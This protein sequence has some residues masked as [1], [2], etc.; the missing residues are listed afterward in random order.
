TAT[1]L[2][3]C[4]TLSVPQPPDSTM[5]RLPGVVELAPVRREAVEPKREQLV[6]GFAG[7][8]RP[9]LVPPADDTAQNGWHLAAHDSV[10]VRLA[11]NGRSVLLTFPAR[12][13]EPRMG[14]ATATA[15]VGMPAWGG[16]VIVRR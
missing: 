15:P 9:L 5:L 3:G 13:P 7:V 4:Y 11:T 2:A 16:L 12:A 1:D 14:Y 8:Q 6:Q 10:A